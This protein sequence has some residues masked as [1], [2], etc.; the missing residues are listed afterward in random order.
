MSKNT[1]ASGARN[2]IHVTAA[3][4]RAAVGAGAIAVAAQALSG[5]AVHA[6]ALGARVLPESI[7]GRI[8]AGGLF[9]LAIAVL[10]LCLILGWRVRVTASLL[11]LA[12]LASG[13]VMHPFWAFGAGPLQAIQLRLF[14]ASLVAATLCAIAAW[15]GA[16]VYSLD[17][18]RLRQSQAR[19]VR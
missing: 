9:A 15:L 6:M 8:A 13:V 14:A 4:L 11:A 7:M 12:A 16:G 19:A 2:P 3:L 17:A 1:R 5:L 18:G 10:G